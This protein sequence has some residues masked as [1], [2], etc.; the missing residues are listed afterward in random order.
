MKTLSL[1]LPER[2]HALLN[3]A[4]LERHKAKSELVREALNA[5]LTSKA[6]YRQGSFA[7]LTDDLAGRIKGPPDLAGNSRHLE[8]FGR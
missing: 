5:Y 6:G 2:L 7:A 4:V 8:G 1:K 3:A